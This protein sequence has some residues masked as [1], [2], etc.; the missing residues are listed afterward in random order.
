MSEASATAS[1]LR[2]VPYHLA[3]VAYLKTHEDDLWQWFSS[4][5][6]S[7]ERLDAVRLDLLKSTYRVERGSAPEL[8]AAADAAATALAIAAPLTIYQ[9][10]NPLGMNAAVAYIPGEI[11][12]ILQGAVAQTLTPG[13]L[14]ALF[15]HEFAHFL[16]HEGWERQFHVAAAILAAMNNDRLAGTEHAESLRLFTLY[17][18][19]FCD[20]AALRVCGELSLVVSAQLKVQTGLPSVSPES[21]LRQA[22][23]ISQMD[24]P[25]TDESTHP[26]GFIRARSLRLWQE[27][28][29]AVDAEIARMIEGTPEFDRLDLLGKM[30]VA[31][32][33]RKLIDT[34]LRHVW[35]RTDA[36]LGHARLFF[37]D[38]T[39]S[40][41]P[42]AVD[43]LAAEIAPYDKGLRDYLCYVLLDFA[44][45]D[46][47]L[48]ELPLAAAFE[49]S[50]KLG[51]EKQFSAA[52]AKELVLKKKQLEQLEAAA[53][54]MLAN[55]EA[56]TA[57]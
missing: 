49:L 43:A 25:K 51:L 32:V 57:S 23:E 24:N 38:F 45:V 55:A 5:K 27:R 19:V 10:Q 39:P 9:S 40:A 6:A 31:A 29:D 7:A 15:G 14:Q 35:F 33:T 16:F 12:V 4:D 21:F 41:T 46:R 50:G 8:Y 37:E 47:S 56:G 17:L 52:A 34:L 22:D 48:D 36:V 2:P 1:S 26:E 28:G 13:E 54:E 44:T 30:S 11:H 20:R 42:T 53:S 18:E 3:M